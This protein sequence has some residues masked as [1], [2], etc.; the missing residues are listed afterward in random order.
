MI[1]LF[2]TQN[3]LPNW[4]AAFEYR[5]INSPGSFKNQTATH[6]N[7]R[8]S[9]WYQSKNKRYQNFFVIVGSKLQVSENGGLKSVGDLDSS[10]YSNSFTLPTQLGGNLPYNSNPFSTN[11]STGTKYATGT[12]LMRQQYDLGQ[13]DSIV[14]DTSVIPL[15]YPRLRMEHTITYSTFDYNFID[16]PDSAGALGTASPLDSTYYANYYNIKGLSGSDTFARRDNW[17]QLVND[18]SLYQ[19]PDSKN[20][21]QFIKV[22]ASYEILKAFFDT[23]RVLKGTLN[24][25]NAF[26]H[27]E[28]RNK[29]RNQKWDIEANGKFYLGGMNAGDYNAYISLKRYISRQVGYLQ[30]GFQNVNRTPSF[31]FNP[32]SSFYLDQPA[33]FNKENSTNIFASLEQPQNHFVLKGSYYLISNYAYSSNYYKA[34]QES[35]L[36]NVLA[37]TVQKQF[38]LYRHWKWRTATIFQQ[39]AGA[40]P[41]NIPLIISNNQIGYDGTFGYKNLNISFG[42]EVRYIS[43]YK[44]DGYAPVT[45]QFFTQKDTTIGQHLP[46]ITGYLNFRIRSFTAFV[47]AENLNTL[48]LSGANGFGFS[49]YNFVAPNYPSPGL[50]LRIGIFWGFVD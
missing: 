43:P 28:Y 48:Q 12:F 50:L 34:S 22:G 15:F 37:I 9:S 26:L 39:E 11:I 47:R 36:F 38:T 18:F 29:T 21:Q 45:G 23:S 35:S 33:H 4:N 32:A 6:N 2:H 10:S 27:G 30:V 16:Q 20:A 31:I 1:D 13:K 8:F 14:T 40:S 17:K 7:Y 49:N 19:F 3:I 42:V 25:Y 41:V 46:D 24:D 44:A 5:F